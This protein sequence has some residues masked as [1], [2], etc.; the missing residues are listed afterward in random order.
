MQ[1]PEAHHELVYGP[2]IPADYGKGQ[3]KFSFAPP[4]TPFIFGG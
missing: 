4:Q 2:S 1:M 3:N